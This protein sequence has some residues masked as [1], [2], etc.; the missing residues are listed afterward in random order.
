MADSAIN[1]FFF[2]LR[3]VTVPVI[4]NAECSSTYGST[5]VTDKIICISGANS[6]GICGV[7]NNYLHCCLTLNLNL[8]LKYRVM[9]A[10]VRWI[11]NNQMGRGN[12]LESHRL[13]RPQVVPVANHLDTRDWVLIRLGFSPSCRPIMARPA[14]QW[15]IYRLLF[16]R[17]FSFQSVSFSE[18]AVT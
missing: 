6:L 8:I 15:P 14:P 11:S 3:K 4:S 17:P 16:Y 7:R 10:E 12:R 1:P 18:N 5:V 2:S 9:L 13:L